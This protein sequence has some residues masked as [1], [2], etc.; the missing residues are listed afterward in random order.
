MNMKKAVYVFLVLVLMTGCINHQK[1]DFN[2]TNKDQI[3]KEIAED[4]RNISQVSDLKS[5]DPNDYINNDYYDHILSLGDDAV[6]VLLEMYDSGKLTGL[7]AY[8]AALAIQEITKCQLN[9]WST[10]EAFFDLWKEN[11][12]PSKE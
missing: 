6:T 1:A 4:F 11:E 3:E 9:D 2:T 5:S 8:L 10:A 7:N 12:C